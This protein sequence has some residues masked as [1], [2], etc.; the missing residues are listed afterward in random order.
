M[1]SDILNGQTDMS[2]C[3]LSVE[4]IGHILWIFFE[5][6][7]NMLNYAR[8]YSNISLSNKCE[9]YRMDKMDEQ[10]MKMFK[11]MKNPI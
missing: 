9:A 8:I 11:H 1:G 2:I 4:H 3:P 10:P 6:T 7:L 5:N